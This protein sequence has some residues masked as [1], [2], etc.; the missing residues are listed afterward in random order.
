MSVH[1]NKYRSQG[2]NF[3]IAHE[4]ID[5]CLRVCLL[6]EKYVL[7]FTDLADSYVLLQQVSSDLDVRVVIKLKLVLGLCELKGL[8]GP[9]L[10]PC[11]SLLHLHAANQAWVKGLAR[12]FSKAA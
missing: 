1:S 2:Q 10:Y 6:A 9:S 12:A 3:C 7:G 11:Q 4:V 5:I 8:D